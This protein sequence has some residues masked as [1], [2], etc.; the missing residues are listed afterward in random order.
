MLLWEMQAYLTL[1]FLVQ[2]MLLRKIWQALILMFPAA[3]I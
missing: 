3:E 1:A 2:A